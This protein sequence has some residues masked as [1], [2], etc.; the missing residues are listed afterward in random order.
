LS[1]AVA[2]RCRVFVVVSTIEFNDEALCW[3]EE[4]HDIRSDRRLSPEMCTFYRQLFQSTPEN[5]LMRRGI[6]SQ[7]L[8]CGAPN[9]CLILVD[10][11]RG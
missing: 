7:F 3:T 1:F 11:A 2:S 9:C 8:S 5:P 10:L 6:R 4:V